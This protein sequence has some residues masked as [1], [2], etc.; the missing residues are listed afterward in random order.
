MTIKTSSQ[1]PIGGIA[2]EEDLDLL[3]R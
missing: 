1:F 2:R 3:T